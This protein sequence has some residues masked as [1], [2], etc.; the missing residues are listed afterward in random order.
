MMEKLQ[1]LKARKA[2]Q[3]W[4]AR[5]I[6]TIVSRQRKANLLMEM[7]S[8][9]LRR[10]FQEMKRRFSLKA[11]IVNRLNQLW[12]NQDEEHKRFALVQI[13]QIARMN[14]LRSSKS[15]FNSRN[16]LHHLLSR[17]ETIKMQKSFNKYKQALRS[18]Q[19]RDATLRSIFVKRLVVQYRGYFDVWR[20]NAER[21]KAVEEC[22][23][24][25]RERLEL[26]R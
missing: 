3:I 4:R 25:G 5:A 18:F 2:V 6:K 11:T 17:H 8:L 13:K 14:H 12:L 23:E 21:M 15:R 22:Q 16:A 26:N 19:N 20:K 7:R 9:Y 10:C 24:Q 1:A